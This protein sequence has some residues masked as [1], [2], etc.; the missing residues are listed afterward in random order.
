[1][2]ISYRKSEYGREPLE[3]KGVDIYAY[4]RNPGIDKP[5]C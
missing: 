5:F 1:M 2:K 4:K 3:R